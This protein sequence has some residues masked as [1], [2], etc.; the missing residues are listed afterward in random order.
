MAHPVIVVG[1]GGH[2]RAVADA[3]LCLGAQVLGFTDT[4]AT[5]WGQTHFDLPILGGD[6]ILARQ[7]T[8]KVRL[9]NGLGMVNARSSMLRCR[10]Q[11]VLTLQGWTFVPVCHPSA[12]VSPRAQLADYVQILA[13]AVVQPGAVI[14]TGAIINTRA[15]VEHDARVGEWS[16]V[17]PGALI[18]GEVWLGRHTHVGAGATVRQGLRIG[19]HCLVG[20]G[21]AVVCDIPNSTVAVGVPARPYEPKQ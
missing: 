1:A 13:G 11:E 8:S 20:L 2:A 19:N 3:L 4:D 18:C 9:A 5:M 7:D 16:H 6:D 14:A 17:A 21:S 15:V 10:V 12:I